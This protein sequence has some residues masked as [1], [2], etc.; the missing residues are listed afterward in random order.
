[1]KRKVDFNRNHIAMVLF[2]LY[3]MFATYQCTNIARINLQ[4]TRNFHFKVD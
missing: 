4:I 2:Y 1:M 3:K